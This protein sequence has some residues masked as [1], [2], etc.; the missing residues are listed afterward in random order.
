MLRLMTWNLWWRFGPWEQRQAG[1][2][3]LIEQVAPDILGLQEVWVEQD[4][5]NQAEILAERLGGYHVAHGEL[6]YRDGLAFTNAIL[7]RWPFERVEEIPLPRADGTD[8]FRRAI[9]TSI[10]APFGT[11]PMFTTHLTYQPDHSAERVAQVATLAQSID[12]LCPD[13]EGQ[14]PALLTGDFNAVPDSDEIRTL[15]GR[16]AVHVPNLL[17]NDVWDISGDGSP[18]H[19]WCS[20][21]PHLVDSFW[22]RRRLDYLFVRWPRTKPIGNPVAAHLAGHEPIGGVFPSDHYAV[23]A[24]LRTP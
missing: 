17:F 5:A 24:D 14:F 12:R 9:A 19:T 4:G 10:R 1:I 15:T 18:G 7:S 23:W 6:R 13:P 2:A 22:P 20:S 3:Q 11:V 8:S 16:S 21:N